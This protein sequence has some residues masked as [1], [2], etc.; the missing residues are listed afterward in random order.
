MSLQTKTIVPSR[1]ITFTIPNPSIHH[2]YNASHLRIAVLD[3]SSPSGRTKFGVIVVPVGLESDWVYSTFEGHLQILLCH[4]DFYRLVLIGNSPNPINPTSHSPVINPKDQSVIQRAFIRLLNDELKPSNQ[5]STVWFSTRVD[6]VIRSLV[7]GRF[8]GKII[9]E[10][11]IED[12]EWKLENGVGT[13][14]RRRMRFRKSPYLFET[15]MKIQP[16]KTDFVN[17]E[18]VEFEIVDDGVLR[19]SYLTPMV[20]GLRVNH[21]L[22]NRKIQKGIKPTALCLGVGTGALVAFLNSQLGFKVLGIETDSIVLDAAKNYFGF[23]SSNNS[24]LCTGHPLKMAEKFATQVETDGF[25]GYILDDGECLNEFDDKFD[26]VISDLE[27]ANPS[28]VMKSPSAEI[29]QKSMLMNIKKLL[30][31]N[32]VLILDVTIP[33]ERYYDEVITPV[34]EVFGEMYEID[35]ENEKYSVVIAASETE[36]GAFD[37]SESEFLKTLKKVTGSFP[38]AVKPVSKKR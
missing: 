18:D 7:L 22:L 28:V 35:V 27:A 11:L 29:L 38:E 37:P 20:A 17:M 15:Y 36:F 33:R 16:N 12:V 5:S 9:G 8:F 13:E 26:V 24:R 2:H 32:G 25:H 34:M 21:L 4:T 3:S 6:M 31:V 10:M 30:G 14:F 23:E 19:P 1:Y